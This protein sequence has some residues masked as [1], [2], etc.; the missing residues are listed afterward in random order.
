[1]KRVLVFVFVLVLTVSLVCGSWA[2]VKKSAAREA[3]PVFPTTTK[4]AAPTVVAPAKVAPA[5]AP[6]K[7][8]QSAA[9][10][11]F[12]V[13]AGYGAGG[14]VA[15]IGISRPFR[16]GL[17][18]SGGLGLGVGSGYSVVVIDPIRATFDRG[19]YALGLG[20]NYA[21]YST[22]VDI[23]GV[24]SLSNRNVLGLEV[25]GQKEINKYLARVGYSTALGLRASLIFDF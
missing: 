12:F 15:E 9:K 8:A 1:M 20:L 4:Q 2:A 19:Q 16:E 5:A 3:K 22:L 10:R 11:G 21:I 7:P 18:L 14:G 23:P 24:G 6:A 17:V 13:E 25:F